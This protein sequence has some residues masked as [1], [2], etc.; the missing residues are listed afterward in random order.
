MHVCW[1]MEILQSFHFMMFKPCHVKLEYANMQ[2]FGIRV[3]QNS[4][5]LNCEFFDLDLQGFA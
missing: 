2:A 3:K 5:T 4:S 1:I